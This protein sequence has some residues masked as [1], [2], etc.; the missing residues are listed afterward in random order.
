MPTKPTPNWVRQ[1]RAACPRG[2][3]VKESCGKIRLS[4]R[5]GAG[6]K[7]CSTVTLPLPWAADVTSDA[8]TLILELQS[9]LAAGV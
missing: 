4:V 8:I 1:L 5:T 6:G 3:S 7:T 9:K 2:W